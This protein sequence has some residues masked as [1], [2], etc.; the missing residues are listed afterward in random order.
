MPSV[1]RNALWNVLAGMS[2]ALMGVLLPPFLTRLLPPEQFGAWAFSLQVASYINILNF[3]LQ[4]IV[5]RLVAEADARQDFALRDSVVSTAFAALM[6]AGLVGFVGIS[7][8]A[9][10]IDA[11]VPDASA[12][13]KADMV[14]AMLWLAASFVVQLPAS[15]LLA[16]FVGMRQNG[17][18]AFAT[19]L[20]RVMSFFAV[21]GVGYVTREVGA[22]AIA[23]FLATLGGALITW[24]LW[25]SRVPDPRL[26]LRLVSRSS[27]WKLCQE[28]VALTIWNI[29]ALLSSGIQIVLVAR[30]D[31]Q[32]VP[33]F[34]AISSIT[35]LLVGFMQALTGTLVPQAAN[36][37][38]AGRLT[39]LN[40]L[41]IKMGRISV[42]LLSSGSTVLVFGAYW[43]LDLWLGPDYARSGATLLAVI[44]I[45]QATRHL[46]VTYTMA[47][48]GMGQQ[49]RLILFPLIEGLASFLLAIVWVQYYGAIG[50]GFAMIAASVLGAGLMLMQGA[51][52]DRLPSFRSSHF[53]IHAMLVPAVPLF[54]SAAMLWAGAIQAMTFSAA[55]LAVVV[56]LA[57]G[58]VL[59]LNKSDIAMMQNML[60]RR[61]TTP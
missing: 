52:R 4:M 26:S 58:A 33:Q 61:A 49:S 22:M 16:V 45:A 55:V 44:A 43:I 51:A 10:R 17:Y 28:S 30:Y 21:I 46:G 60:S 35:L 2:A 32:S 57:V 18:F 19:L 6:V 12:A 8:I 5:G 36:M 25:R 11:I 15:V 24:L 7:V 34:A 3:G 59:A 56:I 50:V 54:I 39:E 42:L 27:V 31:Y 53:V 40:A 20:T 29:S 1:S 14:I 48:I 41:I 9:G 23:W 47:L 38:A 37:L 13:A